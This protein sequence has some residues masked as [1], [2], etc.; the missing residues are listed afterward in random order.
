MNSINRQDVIDANRAVHTAAAPIYRSAEPHFRPENVS[1]VSAILVELRKGTPAGPLLDIGCGTGFIIEIAGRY[2][3]AIW[4]ID[5]TP[6]MVRQMPASVRTGR[7]AVGLAASELLP[8]KKNSFSVCTAHAVLHHLHDVRPTLAEAFRVLQPNGIFYSDLDPN[9]FFW[10]AV[11]D[12][13]DTNIANKTIVREI[14]AVRY[15][16]LELAQQLGVAK[17]MI[18]KAEP[19]KHIEG[20]LKEETII[21]TLREIGFSSIEIHYEWFLGEAQYIHAAND[22]SSAQVVRTYLRAM[23]PLSRHLFKYISI[24]ARK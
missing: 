20:G 24:R 5:I 16:D 9:A 10:S 1:R 21:A 13:S 11:S 8:F 14:N 18:Q 23:L 15:K 19:I 12:I 7:C 4:G 6:A 17:E 22:A 3:D 2:F